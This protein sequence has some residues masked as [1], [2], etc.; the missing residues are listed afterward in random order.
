MPKKQRKFGVFYSVPD[1]GLARNVS[2]KA[3]HLE[4]YQL[5]GKPV[6]RVNMTAAH[7]HTPTEV[8][9]LAKNLLAIAKEMRDVLKEA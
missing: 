5:R 7:L 6:V 9:H 3:Y 8:E 1:D 4:T 2:Q